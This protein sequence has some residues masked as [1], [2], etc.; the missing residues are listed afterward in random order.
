LK[1]FA[2]FRDRRRFIGATLLIVAISI[3]TTL[4]DRA[5]AF[6]R[7]ESTSIDHF[8]RLA[9]RDQPND[10]FVVR[11]DDDDYASLFHRSC[12][13]DPA[14]LRSVID[15]VALANPREIVVDVL[16]TDDA[17]K[18]RFAVNATW[19]T[20]VWA[21]DAV[22]TPAGERPEPVL[23]G[24]RV[25]TGDRVGLARVPIDEDGVIRRYARTWPTVAGDVP[26]LPHAA[27]LAT[28]GIGDAPKESDDEEFLNFAGQRW[29]YTSSGYPASRV[30]WLAQQPAWKNNPVFR[31]KIVVIGGYYREARDTFA[32]PVGIRHGVDVIA[33]AIDTDLHG[34]GIRPLNEAIAFALDVLLGY[35]LVAFGEFL[36]TPRM[37][38]LGFGG[39]A[40]LALFASYATFSTF[41]HWF[42]F[43]P[44]IA[45]VV[46]HELYHHGREY[47]RLIAE[48][49]ERDARE[50][51]APAGNDHAKP[52]ATASPNDEDS[53]LPTPS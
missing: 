22:D 26:T 53:G 43:I 19:P 1:P 6:D 21:Q 46:V 25:R 18:D 33:Q 17:F 23:G 44:M 36:R 38:L 12:P 28:Y 49:D 48:R 37:L 11:I 9:P 50:R 34:N 42:N 27:V 51:D 35:L 39:F 47:E 15:A 29:D 10:V 4:L 41:G 3:A 7:Y 20:I 52:L 13:L 14:T 5:G 45:G 32:T 30:L 2:E 16:T 24:Q 31:G 40:L 8:F